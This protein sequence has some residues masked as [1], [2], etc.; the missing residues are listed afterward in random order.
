MVLLQPP[1]RGGGTPRSSYLGCPSLGNWRVRWN[2]G[3]QNEKRPPEGA[4]KK[5]ADLGLHTKLFMHLDSEK[6][7]IFFASSAKSRDF[8]QAPPRGGAD[9]S[10]EL[11]SPCVPSNFLTNNTVYRPLYGVRSTILAAAPC[12][13]S[14]LLGLSSNVR[15]FHRPWSKAEVYL[16][17]AFPADAGNKA[18]QETPFNQHISSPKKVC[19]PTFKK[20]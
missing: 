11:Q 13:W 17:G 3:K 14:R 16:I 10:P 6:A 12:F 20:K 2:A 8:E 15:Y 5:G 9:A 19:E 7:M 18:H 1:L 4:L